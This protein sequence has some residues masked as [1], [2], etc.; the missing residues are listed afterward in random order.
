MKAFTV[1]DVFKIARFTDAPRIIR[2]V[3][4][5]LGVSIM[6]VRTFVTRLGYDVM[7]HAGWHDRSVSMVTG[8]KFHNTEKCLAVSSCLNDY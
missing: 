5:T 2:H 6:L 1:H 7:S 3:S 8:L 4:L